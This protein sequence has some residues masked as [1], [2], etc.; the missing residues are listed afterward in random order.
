MSQLALETVEWPT[1]VGTITSSSVVE[2]RSGRGVAH[3]PTVSY[4]Y[5]VAGVARTGRAIDLTGGSELENQAQRKISKYP[6]GAAVQVYYN[7]DKPG[8]SLLSPG[9]NGFMWAVLSLSLVVIGAGCV[10]LYYYRPRP[11]TPSVA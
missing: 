5:E 4:S 8:E 7:R 1:V 9:M 10:G 3:Y 11:A 2:D 6:V